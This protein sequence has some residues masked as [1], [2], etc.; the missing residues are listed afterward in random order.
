MV[1]R[2]T[3]STL[4]AEVH[5]ALRREIIS[6]LLRPGERLRLVEVAR[7]YSTSSTVVRDA[8]GRLVADKLVVTRPN[9]GFFVL[10]LDLQQL[11]DLT[12]VRVQCDGLAMEFAIERG[13]LAWETAV[14]SAH[15]V[16]SR[17]P[18]RLSADPDHTTEQWAQAHR[19]FHLTLISACK[20]PLLVD[21]SAATFDSTELYRRW[22]A[23]S[24]DAT[25]RSIED[26]HDA[27][28][29]AA[30]SRDVAGAVRHLRS[31]YERTLEVI[32][33]SGVV[34]GDGDKRAQPAVLQQP[35]R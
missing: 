31:H 8:L 26:E 10:A 5:L 33:S 7:R 12:R 32:L 14:M 25:N 16:L 9:Q 3:A 27:I 6:G 20:V 21:L 13:D 22:S 29:Q 4:A 15:H 24:I 28:V 1:R 23:P 34:I 30:L 19:D 11:E 2:G 17:T 35:P 18:R